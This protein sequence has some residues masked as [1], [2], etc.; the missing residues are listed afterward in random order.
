[1]S[2]EFVDFAES[3]S[4]SEYLLD[5]QGLFSLADFHGVL[6]AGT[7]GATSPRRPTGSMVFA[8][9]LFSG[10]GVF[11]LPG[12]ALS[13]SLLLCAT[14]AGSIEFRGG[15][16]LSIVSTGSLVTVSVGDVVAASAPVSGSWT[17]KIVFGST[18]SVV[19][20][21]DEEV[22]RRRMSP[23]STVATLDLSIYQLDIVPQ[24]SVH[25]NRRGPIRE[26]LFLCRRGELATPSVNK[27]GAYLL[28]LSEANGRLNGVVLSHEL[29]GE[30]DCF[31]LS[32]AS[33]RVLAV[34]ISPDTS[35]ASIAAENLVGDVTFFV[36]A[37]ATVQFHFARTDRCECGT[38][39]MEEVLPSDFIGVDSLPMAPSNAHLFLERG[40][41][42]VLYPAN[43]R[44]LV[45]TTL[46][47]FCPFKATCAQSSPPSVFGFEQVPEGNPVAAKRALHRL[48]YI[49]F[50]EIVDKSLNKPTTTSIL[51]Y[52]YFSMMYNVSTLFSPQEPYVDNTSTP[53]DYALLKSQIA[54]LEGEGVRASTLATL[55]FHA[56]QAWCPVLLVA[57]SNV[58]R[59]AGLTLADLG[60]EAMPVD[61]RYVEM[62]RTWAL[63][64][65]RSRDAD[66]PKAGT[67]PQASDPGVRADVTGNQAT[68]NADPL[69]WHPLVF[70]KGTNS[71]SVN[72]HDVP[73]VDTAIPASFGKQPYLGA[74]WGTVGGFAMAPGAAL[75]FRS[76]IP[77]TWDNPSAATD[78][79]REAERLLQVYSTLSDEQMAIAEVFA[80]SGAPNLPPPG[81]FF[82]VALGLSERHRQSLF[83]DVKL[84]FLLG[85]AVF[86]A[87]LAAWWY[88]AQ[89][90]QTR[91]V[92]AIRHYYKDQA[93]RSWT[94]YQGVATITGSQ[95]LPYQ[96]LTFVTP[97]FPDVCSGHSTFSASAGGILQWWFDSDVL[98]DGSSLMEL[99]D[100]HLVSLVLDPTVKTVALGEYICKVGDSFVEPGV[101][102]HKTVILR[103]RTISDLVN[104]AGMSRI[105]GGI[106]WFHT[107]DVSLRLGNWN[108]QQVIAKAA[109]LGIE[110]P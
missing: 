8:D 5:S 25:R 84:F 85:C 100:P 3:A 46:K 22:G 63:S 36:G 108:A 23:R 37:R 35:V 87:S 62:I 52:L 96:D 57:G 109:T 73:V 98:Y 17:L 89:F 12:T 47:T 104:A 79:H 24:A 38:V 64:H 77:T 54:G 1:M 71:V 67:T 30:G 66:L 82:I 28:H 53:S 15:D 97:P 101:S 43:D 70:P 11:A 29:F 21:N 102:P 49:L 39:L 60:L 88:K 40:L 20:V 94:P 99:P 13:G 78:L 106:H 83:D 107:N 81:F 58:Y 50:R 27:Y 110:R 105:Y 55:L 41:F 92:T 72:G 48:M 93:I 95:W 68:D 86:D 69:H 45:S 34:D 19:F 14:G 56:H 2:V 74:Q 16:K 103:Y 18:T 61:A 59:Y 26:G 4:S 9:G 51:F 6:N 75:D 32:R 91:P 44:P 76:E 80:G 65:A 33:R 90:L 10:S 42:D 31:D 7:L